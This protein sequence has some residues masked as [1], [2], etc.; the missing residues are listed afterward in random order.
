MNIIYQLLD[1]EFARAYLA[2][3]L[4][5]CY[6]A[7]KS[8]GE[9]II[10]PVKQHI[11]EHTYHVVIEYQTEL[12]SRKGQV[13]N[14]PIYASAHS[15]E[16]R[17]NV[18]DGMK[19]LWRHGFYRGKLT[20]PRP[21]FYSQQF[22]AV[23]YRGIRGRSLYEYI[24]AGEP[25]AVAEM[26]ARTA[27]LFAKLHCLPV[28]AARNFN[29]KNSRLDTVIPSISHMN[30]R[31]KDKYPHLHS[32]FKKIYNI[33]I[34]AEKAFL[35]DPR[36]RWLVHGD[37]HPGNVIKIDGQKAGLIDFTDLCL[38]DFARDLGSFL[39]Q[40]QYMMRSNNFSEDFIVEQKD[41]F[42]RSYQASAK[43]KVDDEIQ[44]RIKIYY[45]WTVL[46]TAAT[47]LLKEKADPA[48]AE[49]MIRSV[50]EEMRVTF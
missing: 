50:A 29:R 30:Q 41:S 49:K 24:R 43:M 46:R 48:E 22:K 19:F 17:K 40:T 31:I 20:M 14:L 39:Q 45:Y 1:P 44:Q 3:R 27:G 6:P 10:R 13:L 8:L 38:A 12:L 7:Y 5:P 42:I 47:F 25:V 28:A 9:I 37:A 26:I 36:H 35:T 23:F 18:Y 4:L 32:P 11:W 34:A 15:N 2:E 16:P 21:L 33:F